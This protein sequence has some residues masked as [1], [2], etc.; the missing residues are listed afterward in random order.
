MFTWMWT[1]KFTKMASRLQSLEAVRDEN[2]LSTDLSAQTLSS[3]PDFW[4]RQHEA[5]TYVNRK[6][7]KMGRQ[8]RAWGGLALVAILADAAIVV[9][10]I[11]LFQ[12]TQRHQA[13]QTVLRLDQQLHANPVDDVMEDLQRV[14]FDTSLRPEVRAQAQQ[15]L[16]FMMMTSPM[17]GIQT[18]TTSPL[19]QQL[20]A[21]ARLGQSQAAEAVGPLTQLLQS[22]DPSIRAEAARALGNIGD[23]GAI[24][25]IHNLLQQEPDFGVRQAAIYA[26]AQLIAFNPGIQIQ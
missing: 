19:E 2:V 23:S 12:V 15:A 3:A 1:R 14:A 22:Q 11:T 16:S 4:Q 7:Q 21:I 20:N 10:G 24:G 17:G 6:M 13:V 25:S 18:G 9:G 5:F 26:A 8:T